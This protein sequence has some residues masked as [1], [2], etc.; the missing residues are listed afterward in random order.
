MKLDFNSLQKTFQSQADP[1]TAAGQKAYMKN[2]F[3]FHGIK[4]PLRRKIQK[5]FLKKEIVTHSA[6]RKEVIENLWS[7]RERE[8]QYFAQELIFTVRKKLEKEEITL[9][10]KMVTQKSWW[11]TVD[12]IATKLAAQY[13]ISYPEAIFPKINQWL[14]SDNI[15]L[16]RTAILFQLHY[17]EKTDTELLAYIIESQYGSKEFFINKA[18]GWVLRQ[19]SRTNPDWVRS[20]IESH[21]LHPLSKREGGRLLN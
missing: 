2:R 4:T 19:Y 20:F 11:D 3:D 13:F 17:K 12:F 16:I 14:E 9:I 5:P 8:Y 1:E 21:D 15:W 18:I 6:Q 7:A 10:E